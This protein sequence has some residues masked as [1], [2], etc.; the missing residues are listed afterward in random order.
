MMSFE[1]PELKVP[2]MPMT[3][4]SAAYA[5][6][7]AEHTAGSYRPAC[8]VEL[9]HSWYPTVYFPALKLYCFSSTYRI[10]CPIRRF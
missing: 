5:R 2:R 4:F 6:P 3:F 7:F 8:A 10:A 9:S 1:H